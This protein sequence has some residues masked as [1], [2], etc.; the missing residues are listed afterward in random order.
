MAAACHAPP[1]AG[2]ALPSS[3]CDA[4]VQARQRRSSSLN[5]RLEPPEAVAA[6]AAVALSRATSRDATGAW[7]A[8]ASEVLVAL[9]HAAQAAPNARKVRL[10]WALCGAE[11][12]LTR[13]PA[14]VRVASGNC[15][16]GLCGGISRVASRCWCR[17]R[18]AAPDHSGGD[19]AR[20]ALPRQPGQRSPAGCH[21]RGSVGS[22]YRCARCRAASPE[23]SQGNRAASRQRC[24]CTAQLAAGGFIPPRLFPRAIRH[25]R[26]L[27]F[28]ESTRDLTRSLRR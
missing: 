7:R 23:A 26:R 12:R 13:R 15:T 25:A 24:G 22:V 3:V 4:L 28:T 21:F 9:Q 20:C 10:R 19:A 17:G 27:H 16:A 8:L 5:A 2:D 1:A 18:G 6:A 11:L 14:D